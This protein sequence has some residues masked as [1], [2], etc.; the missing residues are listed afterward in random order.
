MNANEELLAGYAD[1]DSS[2]PDD[3]PDA[4][5]FEYKLC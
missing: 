2:Y 4:T 1:P 3:D 5:L